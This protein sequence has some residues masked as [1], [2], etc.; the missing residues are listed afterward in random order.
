M[1]C[2]YGEG[3]CAVRLPRR[4]MAAHEE[5]TSFHWPL[6]VQSMRRLE[7]RVRELEDEKQMTSNPLM[8]TSRLQKI[9]SQVAAM[10]Q[11]V[12]GLEHALDERLGEIEA[13]A[14]ELE[15]RVNKFQAGGGG[16]GGLADDMAERLRR[17]ED[18]LYDLERSMSLRL[19]FKVKET[20]LPRVVHSPV[21]TAAGGRSINL[22]FGPSHMM[23]AGSEEGLRAAGTGTHGV[24]LF[25]AGGAM[26]ATAKITFELVADG[27]GGGGGG[28]TLL[29]TKG[30]VLH[31]CETE[32]N[33]VNKGAAP[34]Q[35]S[36]LP[37]F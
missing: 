2:S 13:D 1:P 5:D 12:V 34:I 26:P 30:S 4:D 10:E 25:V 19:V 22:T 18:Q 27:P 31:R 33:A 29:T 37:R 9:E 23:W 35:P 21:V 11:S 36:I 6:V 8:Q 15:S 20:D 32:I 14:D 7:G 24:W 3:V 16:G 28:S 17:C